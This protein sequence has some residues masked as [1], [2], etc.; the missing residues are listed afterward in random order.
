[1][2]EVMAEKKWNQN[3]RIELLQA[4]SEKERGV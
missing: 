1:M 4:H 3:L 2:E